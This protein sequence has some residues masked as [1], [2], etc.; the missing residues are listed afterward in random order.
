MAAYLCAYDLSRFNAKAPP[1]QTP[2]FFAIVDANRAPED[3][4]LADA[5]E[6]LHAPAA[7]TLTALAG[8]VPSE[9]SVW[10]KDRKNAKLIPHRL[11][12]AGY[13]AVR[14]PAAKDGYWRLEGRRQAVYARYDLPL[15]DQLAAAGA[16][17]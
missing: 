9:F 2:A 16:L 4:E 5:L 14:N 3:A 10:L 11:E 6:A 8:P 12:A 13:I 15:R 7:I 1:L 17:R